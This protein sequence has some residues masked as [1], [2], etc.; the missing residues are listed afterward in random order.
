M[1]GA[2]AMRK[3]AIPAGHR[4]TLRRT[5]IATPR[6]TW[7]PL[8]RAGI[9]MELVSSTPTQQVFKITHSQSYQELE[10][11]F[12]RALRTL[13]PAQF[14]L[15][16]NLFPYHINSLLQFSEI[17]KIHGDMQTAHDFVERAL[18][19]LELNFHPL[20]NPALGT[21]RLDYGH[22]ENRA[23]FLALFRHV[24]FV[25]QRGCWRTA[26]EC[27][28]FL[29]SLDPDNDPLGALLLIDYLAIRSGEYDFFERFFSEMHI[30]LNLM[31]LPNFALSR[32]LIAFLRH[33][34]GA[35]GG[36]RDEANAYLADALMRFPEA[37]RYM[38]DKTDA[39]VRPRVAACPLFAVPT[40][41][42][43]ESLKNVRL[44]IILYVERSH[45]VWKGS[46]IA[47]WI[48]VRSYMRMFFIPLCHC[49]SLSPFVC[50]FL[51][52]RMWLSLLWIEKPPRTR[53]CRVT[54]TGAFTAYPT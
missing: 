49:S 33:R 9:Q 14:S 10:M 38:C 37:L 40:V 50:L 11:Q 42:A 25:G 29:M 17:Y 51:M 19:C 18:F 3:D 43:N 23:L 48:M 34:E 15:I 20:F 45:S 13:D 5:V 16:L 46:D 4:R 35:K 36:S 32:A 53:F 31:W 27:C 8:T 2:E 39:R 54:R 52:R 47:D 22:Y 12:F 28:K 30:S 24:S 44:L 21:C 1:F 41:P 6:V 26:L 7:P